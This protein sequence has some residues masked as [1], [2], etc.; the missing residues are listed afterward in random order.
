LG[1]YDDQ[2]TVIEDADERRLLGWLAPGA[3][4]FSV[5]RLFIAKLMPRAMFKFTTDQS[6]GERVMVPIGLFEKVWPFDLL[7][8]PLLRALL[9]GDDETAEALG[10]LELAEEDVAACSFVCPSKIDY[11]RALR[12]ALDRIEEQG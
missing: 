12:A 3:D 2:I 10:C 1:P 5:S 8:T 4:T 11:G 7:V 9:S 6:G